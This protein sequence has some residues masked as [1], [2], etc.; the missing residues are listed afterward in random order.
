MTSIYYFLFFSLLGW[1]IEALYRSAI[2]RRLINPGFL[3]GPYLP[4]YGFGGLIILAGHSLLSS[5]NLPV[6]AVFYLV[7]LTALEFLAGFL[8]EKI[9]GVRLWDYHRRRFNLYGY[10]CLRFSLYWLVLAVT[11]DVILRV[12]LPPASVGFRGIGFGGNLALAVGVLVMV[13][14]FFF[15]TLRWADARIHKKEGSE[16][17]RK[18][19]HSLAAPTLQHPDVARLKEIN[20]HFGKTRLDH[21]LEVAWLAFKMSKFF[22]LDHRV[23]IRGSLLHDLFYY[24][25]FREGPRWHG[26]RHPR[27]ALENARKVTSL[28]ARE[29]DSILR[30]MWP[31][32][33]I[34]PRY[35][36][37][38]CVCLADKYCSWRDYLGPIGL[39]LVGR[40]NAWIKRTNGRFPSYHSLKGHDG[41]GENSRVLLAPSKRSAARSLNILLIDAQPRNL[42]F[43][44]FRTLTLP[45]LAGATSSRHRVHLMDGRVEKIRIP[46]QGVDLVGVS[47]S[48]NNASLAYHISKTARKQGIKTVAGGTHATAVPHEVLEHFDAVLTGEAE[49][50]AWSHLLDD[51]V[52]GSLDERYGNK[53]APDISRLSSP[54]LDMLPARRYLPAYPV[55]ATRGCPNRCDFCFNRYVHPVYRKRPID[56]VVADV[57]RA[58]RKNI[59]FMD[60][61]LTVDAAYAK[62]LFR[63]LGPLKKHLYFQMQLSAAEDEELIHLA[64]MAGCKG[65]FCGLESINAASLDSVSKSFN[66]IEMY[67]TQLARLDRR[68][69]FVVGGLIFGLDGDNR[70]VFRQTMDF[71]NSSGICSAVINLVIPYPG[72]GF[73]AQLKEEGRLLDLDYRNYT[74]YRLVVAPKG[75]STEELEQG[76]KRFIQE[77]YSVKTLVNRFRNQKRPLRQLPAYALVN[78]AYRLPR[79]AQSRSLLG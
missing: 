1:I 16:T 22:D 26:L 61:N 56:Q 68:G 40:R 31:L 34:P 15:S 37:S 43:T 57:M 70:Q 73:H 20:H 78:L 53:R 64:S 13:M 7:S 39:L 28:S 71:L 12:A 48:C 54:R 60:D 11:V 8:M 4:I 21:V 5:Y 79:Q 23:V 52:H 67:K 29:R 42:P 24:D 58:D 41:Y 50:G 72:T 77:F 62:E 51:V 30:H 18:L 9:F 75:M 49:G 14:D 25:W 27:I 76:Y 46:C 74:G 3:A 33:P 66:Q 36:E 69:I 55:E 19:F 44:A 59:F 38:F 17:L 2:D 45:R 35:L 10:I 6:R 65:I 47:F 32:T 63:A